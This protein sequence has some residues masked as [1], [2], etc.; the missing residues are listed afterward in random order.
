MLEIYQHT[1]SCA[2]NKIPGFDL[3]LRIGLAADPAVVVGCSVLERSLKSGGCVHEGRILLVEWSQKFH[4]VFRC[5]F[6]IWLSWLSATIPQ[7]AVVSV[8]KQQKR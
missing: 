2:C 5:G 3:D 7:W 1:N 8:E 4:I 6:G